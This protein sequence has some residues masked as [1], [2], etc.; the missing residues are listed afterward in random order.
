M[1]QR[2][3][4]VIDDEPSIRES[5]TEFL[6]D[7]DF[8][9]TAASSA[10]EGLEILKQQPLDAVVADLRLGGMSGDTMIPL[11]HKLQ[12]HLHFLIH[13]GSAGYHLSEELIDLGMTPKSVM[14]KPL[15][16]MMILIDSLEN[17]L[18]QA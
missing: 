1:V 17:L 11:A 14:L 3:V 13:T 4:L 9:V 8:K 7:F 5:L 15:P 10:E 18:A 16:D 2:R 12:P 6:E